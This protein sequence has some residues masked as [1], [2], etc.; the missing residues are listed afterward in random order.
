MKKEQ[1]IGTVWSQIT[2]SIPLILIMASI[3][4]SYYTVKIELAI[5]NERMNTLA[6]GNKGV[7]EIANEDRKRL[8]GVEVRVATLEER[9]RELRVSEMASAAAITVQLTPTQTN[10]SAQLK[11]TIITN[12]N[13]FQKQPH[14][15]ALSFEPESYPEPILPPLDIEGDIKKIVQD[16]KNGVGL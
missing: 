12:V 16:L 4:G 15:P 9:T 7:V 13:Y 1:N 5:M 14:S 8:R 10:Q 3:F 6:E 2:S 11:P